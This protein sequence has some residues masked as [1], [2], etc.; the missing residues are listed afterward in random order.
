MGVW[1]AGGI[2]GAHL[3][4]AVCGGNPRQNGITNIVAFRSLFPWQS[5]EDSHG[6]KFRY[7]SVSSI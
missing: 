2:S 7:A 3:N 4:P 6:R 5:F 1:V